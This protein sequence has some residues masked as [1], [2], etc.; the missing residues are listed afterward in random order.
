M[1]VKEL[2]LAVVVMTI[3]TV[4]TV[5]S[6][7]AQDYTT[8]RYTYEG[9]GSVNTHWIET[10]DSV[11]V[12]D[13]QRDTIHAA[14]ALAAVKTLGKPVV[15]ILITHGH[16]DHYTG[17][18]QFLA[19]WPGANVYASAETARVI[20]TDHYGYHQVVRELAPD[21]APNRFIVPNRVFSDNATLDIDGVEI[22]TREMG[23]SEAT[24]AT[25]YYLP[26]SADIYLGD[27]VLN[28][29]HGFFLEERS[30]QVLATL[31][32]AR[33]LFPK[34]EIA[35]PGHGDPG[36]FIELVDRQREYTLTARRLVAEALADGRGGP[37]AV[38]A[39]EDQLIELYP[40][41]GVPGGQPN[42]IE[43]SI[44]GLFAEISAI[45]ALAED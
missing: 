1:I 41:Y 37:D 15:A 4:G 19:E 9:H 10:D 43:L 36:P 28:R 13:L 25:I 11:I 6:G 21:A 30:S 24:G 3:A 8:G 26:K 22:V 35:H 14:E 2:F 12:I 29:M 31:D 42:M 39:V 45:R 27:L 5:A 40:T 44:Q 23:P 34:A 17:V 38:A 32:R 33:V 18:E 20:E 16:P 7:L